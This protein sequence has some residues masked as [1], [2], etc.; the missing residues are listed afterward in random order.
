MGRGSIGPSK[1]VLKNYAA[2]I[3]CV[4]HKSF[5]DAETSIT[6]SLTDITLTMAE[7]GL[8]TAQEDS[9]CEA[10]IMSRAIDSSYD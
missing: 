8:C 5:S 10:S 7:T 9:S 4:D 2:A 1:T 6:A 3:G